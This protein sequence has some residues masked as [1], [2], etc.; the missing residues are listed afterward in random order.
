MGSSSPSAGIAVPSSPLML[1]MAKS[2]YLKNPRM[3]RFPTTDRISTPLAP[4][5][6]CLRRN[7]PMAR[8]LQ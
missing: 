3:E 1:L 5:S 2:V 4:F 7:Q 6:R 8:P